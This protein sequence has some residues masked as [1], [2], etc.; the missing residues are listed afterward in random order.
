[1]AKDKVPP[2]MTPVELDWLTAEAVAQ[3]HVRTIWRHDDP[4][5]TELVLMFFHLLHA[6]RHLLDVEALITRRAEFQEHLDRVFASTG[7]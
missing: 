7:A 3:S 5:E 4:G 1:M 6:R 2:V